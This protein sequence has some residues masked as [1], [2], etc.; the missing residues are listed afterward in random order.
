M[1]AVL[2]RDA[3]RT[4]RALL[5]AAAAAI[6]AHGPGVS[7]DAVAREAG[8]S[9]GG[10]LHHFRTKDTLLVG[11]VEEWTARFDAAVQRHVDPDD[12]RPGRL[13]RAHIRAAF[14]DLGVDDQLWGHPSVLTA[15]LAVPE[16][17][18]RARASEDRWRSDL[19]AD[20]LH[21]QRSL[22]IA[23]TLDG[24]WMS[25]LL[26]GRVDHSERQQTRDLL[27]GLTEQTGPLL[28]GTTDARRDRS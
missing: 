14:D 8:V 4:R 21:P 9:K 19:G 17:L 26:E 11:M 12:D 5:D 6:R 24:V 3:D 13:C 1:G 27:L 18:H 7:L 25:E 10:L 16:V 20:G 2:Q 15:L 22:L 28:P 23:R